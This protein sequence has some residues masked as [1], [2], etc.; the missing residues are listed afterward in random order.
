M[1]SFARAVA[2]GFLFTALSVA[3]GPTAIVGVTVVDPSRDAAHAATKNATVV[4]DGDRIVAVGPSASVNV[5]KDATRID[6][7]NRWLIP[8]MIDGH[9]HFF[10][11]G[12]LYT[13]PDVVDL[14]G[15]VPYAQEVARNKAR[16]PATFKVWLASGVTSVIDVGGP[17]WNFDVRDMAKATDE[18]PRVEV[19]GPLISMVGRPQLELDNDP[20]I[21]KIDSPDA[22]RALVARELK[23]KPD[24]IKVWYIRQKG[25]DPVAQ[26]AIVKATADAAHAAHTRLAVHA[27]ELDVAKSSLRAGADYLVHSVFEEPIDDEFIALMKKNHAL[28]CPTLFVTNGYRLALSNRWQA[29]PDEN[30]LADPKIL[31][32]MHDLDTMPKD[33]VPPRIAKLIAAAP[34]IAA[35][36]VAEQNLKKLRDAGI[37]IVMGTDAGNIG[38]LHGPSVFREMAL[39][40]DAGLTPLEVL[41]SA[42]ANGAK[43][44]GR[45]DLGA[46]EKGKR[47]DMVLLTD[48]PLA[49]VANFSHAERVIKGGAVFDPKK[50]I[51]GIR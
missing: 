3:A 50:L 18:A 16:L 42:T 26:E 10:Q 49:D 31:A 8:G 21:I 30:R 4:F 44:M 6:G 20:P 17:F 37:P 41:R 43:A 24:F 34:P 29:T 48:D 22:A 13:R 15:V 47:A 35:P 32:A 45:D 28:L 9:V 46:I 19:A 12:N 25:D 33:K 1:M 40:R 51:D 38:T 5:P 39:M 11:S 2:A 27:T 7:T 23:R 14:N 36:T